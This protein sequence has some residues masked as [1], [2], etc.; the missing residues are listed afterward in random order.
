MSFEFSLKDPCTYSLAI[1]NGIVETNPC[2]K[3]RKLRENNERKRYLTQDEEGRL[4]AA[5]TAGSAH[6]RPL[7]L[8]AINTGMRRGE[9]LSLAWRNVDFQRSVIHVT[10]TK[11]GRDRD[12]PMNSEVRSILL[13]LQRQGEDEAFVFRSR[14]TGVNLTDVKHGFNGA[15][16]DAGL[17]DFRFHDLRHGRDKVR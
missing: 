16:T 14:K 9:L 17:N 8:M 13:E 10:N 5:L 15:C 12:V 1:D 11:T 7:I 4:M 3:V 6:L 2:R